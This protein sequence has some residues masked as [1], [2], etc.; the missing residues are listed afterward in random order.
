MPD[1][2]DIADGKAKL[3]T[4]TTRAV[5]LPEDLCARVEAQVAPAFGGLVPLL[6]LIL[7]EMARDESGKADREDE[8]MIAARLRDLGY[9]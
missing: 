6:T 4:L 2:V 3:A 7:D 8:K 1:R 9:L 5:L